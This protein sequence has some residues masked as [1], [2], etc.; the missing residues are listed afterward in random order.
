LGLPEFQNHRLAPS[1]D[2]IKKTN[3][4]GSPVVVIEVPGRQR[5]A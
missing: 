3:T 4:V 2:M 5:I 1:R